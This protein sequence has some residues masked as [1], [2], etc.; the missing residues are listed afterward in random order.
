M[1]KQM[2]DGQLLKKWIKLS[3][4]NINEI[5]EDMGFTNYSHL[6]Y[7]YP[8]ERFK[9]TMLDKFC[10]VLHITVDDFYNG[11]LM[12]TVDDSGIALHQGKN[13]QNVL[14]NLPMSATAF[15]GKMNISRNAIYD[16]FKQSKLEDDI[17]NKSAKLLKIQPAML[18]GIDIH[19]YTINDLYYLLKNVNEKLDKLA[20]KNK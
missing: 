17:I 9:K 12:K 6:Y 15:A 19:D 4:K 2:H 13:L 18:K 16:L 3:G 11:E 1:G 14:K 10:K 8:Q 5:L 20:D 7:Y